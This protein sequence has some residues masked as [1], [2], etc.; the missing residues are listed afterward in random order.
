MNR[1][2]QLAA[3]SRRGFLAWTAAVGVAGLAGCKHHEAKKV[4]TPRSQIGDDPA[5]PDSVV[6][7]GAKTDVGNTDPLAVSGVGIVFNLPGT[8]SS[9]PPSG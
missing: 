4:Q 3:L 5:D 8:G 9:P 6:T 2:W 1:A 7:V